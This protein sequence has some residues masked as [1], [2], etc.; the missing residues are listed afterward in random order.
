MK[1]KGICLLAVVFL[2]GGIYGC[3]VETPSRE[4]IL[5]D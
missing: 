3:R 1:R 2:T 5:E 4:A